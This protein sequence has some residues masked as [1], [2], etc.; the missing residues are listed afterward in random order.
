MSCALRWEK[1]KRIPSSTFSE[2]SPVEYFMKVYVAVFSLGSERLV[3]GRAEADFDVVPRAIRA[4]F[5]AIIRSDVVN[6]LS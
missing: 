4:K 3:S 1:F 6:L 2:P 5:I